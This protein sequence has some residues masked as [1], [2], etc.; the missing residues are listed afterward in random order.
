MR[1]DHHVA[2]H[3]GLSARVSGE[4]AVNGRVVFSFLAQH[5]RRPDKRN[6]GM[7]SSPN[8]IW[9]HMTVFENAAFPLQVQGRLS[10]Q[11][12]SRRVA[13]VLEVVALE[14]LG[15]AKRPSFG[16]VSSSA[17]RLPAPSSGA[18]LLL[19]TSPSPTSDAK[20]L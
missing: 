13:K 17:W 16:A 11:G 4:I 7:V 10:R 14:E 5:F 18:R 12:Q 20:Y 19:S 9:P 15:R 8:A 2:F 1:Q 6:F 3:R